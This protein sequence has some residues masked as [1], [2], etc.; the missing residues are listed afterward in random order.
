ML[1]SPS[2]H[3][4]QLAV[5]LCVSAASL[6]ILSC[7]GGDESSEGR[8]VSQGAV[9]YERHC[10]ACHGSDL[11]GTD[12]GPSPLS[13]VYEP[14]HHPD[15]SFRTAIARGSPAHHWNF[16]DMPPIGGLTD[17]EVDDIIGYIRD[18]QDKHGF[19]PYPPPG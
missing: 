7:G 1:R 16:G 6:L 5:G 17:D 9:L 8:P 13:E 19:E 14:G 15:E 10:A 12:R 11:R 4:G 18:Q 2:F 3:L